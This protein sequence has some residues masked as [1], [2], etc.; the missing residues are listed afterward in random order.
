MFFLN[1]FNKSGY[2]RIIWE[3]EATHHRVKE[4]GWVFGHAIAPHG[5]TCD[6]PGAI[7]NFPHQDFRL[8]ISKVFFDNFESCILDSRFSNKFSSECCILNPGFLR[9]EKHFLDHPSRFSPSRLEVWDPQS[10]SESL[11]STNLESQKPCKLRNVSWIQNCKFKISL[12]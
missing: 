5:A 6:P 11:E 3:N 4:T 9:F 1:Y 8:G 7:L 2:Y 12:H 10:F